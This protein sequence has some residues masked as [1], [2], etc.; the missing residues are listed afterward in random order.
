M[1]IASSFSLLLYLTALT[2]YAA[3]AQAQQQ[4]WFERWF[5]EL[6]REK[7]DGPDPAE[8]LQ[9]PFLD[10]ATTITAQ[11]SKI[12]PAWQGKTT[13]IP[14]DKAHRTQGEIANWLESAISYIMS[15]ESNNYLRETQDKVPY[16]T[17][18]GWQQFKGF[19]E[20][21]RLQNAIA[22]DQYTISTFVDDLPLLLN[23]GTLNGRYKWLYEVN[24]M[25]TYREPAMRDYKDHQ[26][27]TQRLK[28][29]LQLTRVENAQNEHD[30]LID[31]WSGNIL[32]VE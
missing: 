20:A 10:S 14:L 17:E 28:V 4:G 1:R 25:I 5:P 15:F 22:S 18:T 16:F 32:A 27:V 11:N 30:I 7:Q 13:L 19:L 29:R 24:A 6:F 23:K 9:A 12:V 21:T 26:P 3:P 8:T 2:L 31:Q